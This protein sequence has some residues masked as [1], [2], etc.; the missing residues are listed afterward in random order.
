MTLKTIVKNVSDK[1]TKNSFIIF[2]NTDIVMTT[3]QEIK[4]IYKIKHNMTLLN[5]N[6]VTFEVTV[7]SDYY[8]QHAPAMRSECT[9]TF[10]F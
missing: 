8:L 7:R 9:L 6:L 2:K 4:N 10:S 3:V 1:W 5:T